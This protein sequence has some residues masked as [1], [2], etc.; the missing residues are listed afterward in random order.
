LKW[1]YLIINGGVANVGDAIQEYSVGLDDG[2]LVGI[3][4]VG[5]AKK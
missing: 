2:D 1:W 4:D 3:S 5:S